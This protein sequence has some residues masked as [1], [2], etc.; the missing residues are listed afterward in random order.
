[1]PKNKVNILTIPLSPLIREGETEPVKSTRIRQEDA[2]DLKNVAEAMAPSV[3]RTFEICGNPWSVISVFSPYSPDIHVMLMETSKNRYLPGPETVPDE[4]GDLLMKLLAKI[5]EFI[6]GREENATF[7]AGYNWSP[8]S[9]GDAEERTGFQS[10]PTKWHPM[11]WG[12]PSLP[13][14]TGLDTKHAKAVPFDQL[15]SQDRRMLGDNDYGIP[16]GR[17]FIKMIEGVFAKNAEFQALFPF[18][19]WQANGLGA[20]I[21]FKFSVPSVFNKPNFFSSI[22]KPMAVALN[23]A[24]IDLTEA[25]T[26]INCEAVDIELRKIADGKPLNVDLLRETPK[27]RRKSEVRKLFHEKGLPDT[28]LEVLLDPVHNR[29]SETGDPSTWWRKGFG[30]SLAFSGPSTEDC[31]ELRIMPGI[32]T[33]P[34]GVVEA[35]GVLIR[36]PEDRQ[37]DLLEAREKSNVQWRLARWLKNL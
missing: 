8:R 27:M 3:L 18:D 24:F 29:C 14:S 26:T 6:A 34:G 28:L 23:R 13:N 22:L 36:R 30:Y 7:Y 21:P 20:S 33:G 25:L 35:N 10:I 12:W 15:S 37:I 2:I 31:G 32:Y 9:W 17:F 5:I 16:F 19:N 4:E 1:L 11:L